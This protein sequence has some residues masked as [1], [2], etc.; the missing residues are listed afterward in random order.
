VASRSLVNLCEAGRTVTVLD[1]MAEWAE[2]DDPPAAGLPALFVFVRMLLVGVDANALAAGT[3]SDGDRTVPTLLRLAAGD[4]DVRI[5]VVRLWKQA[6]RRVETQE[7]AVYAL[8]FWVVLADRRD[9][10]ARVLDV[11]ALDLLHGTR[12]HQNELA[13][14]LR[15]LAND[16]RR[17]STTARRYLQSIGQEV[18][19]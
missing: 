14:L 15:E 18:V 11:V 1:R 16:P 2:V 19:Y 5:R 17:P 6:F 13:D 7:D 4:D 8:K 12:E 3:G 10:A 9:E